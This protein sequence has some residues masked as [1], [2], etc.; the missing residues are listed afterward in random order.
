MIVTVVKVND[1]SYHQGTASFNADAML[2]LV[3]LLFP[4]GCG[5]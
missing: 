4:H 5:A 2:L 3:F 1:N